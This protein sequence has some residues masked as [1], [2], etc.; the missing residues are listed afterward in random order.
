MASVSSSESWEPVFSL[1]VP[2]VD[3]ALLT[4]L[5]EE[6]HA[7]D[8]DD[9]RIGCVMQSLEA[10][11]GPST[12]NG[13]IEPVELNYDD[14]A[15]RGFDYVGLE[16]DR[17]CPMSICRIDDPFV[18]EEMEMAHGSGM[19]QWYLDT[20]MDG[21]ELVG[22]DDGRDYSSFGYGDISMEH[23]YSPLWQ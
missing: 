6:S 7:E 21:I 19:G 3:G 13:G 22:F 16:N 14:G 12:I 2:E 1:E 15:D 23:E 9:E 5:L 11:I 8:A 17:D 10:E 18:W 20:C 4:A